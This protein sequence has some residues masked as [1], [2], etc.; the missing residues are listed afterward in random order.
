MKIYLSSILLGHLSL[1][2]TDV[3]IW[4]VLLHKIQT[5]RLGYVGLDHFIVEFTVCPSYGVTC[6]RV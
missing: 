3:T 5:C 1:R 4:V 6:S 2:D